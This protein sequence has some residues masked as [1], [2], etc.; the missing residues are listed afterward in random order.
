MKNEKEIDFHRL[1]PPTLFSDGQYYD[2]GKPVGKSY[3][4]GKKLIL[5]KND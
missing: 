4:V 2:I 3:V 5:S 1:N